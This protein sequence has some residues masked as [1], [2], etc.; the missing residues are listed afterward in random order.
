MITQAYFTDIQQ[1]ILEKIDAAQH[2]IFV[3]VAWL[4]D[5]VIFEKLCEKAKAEVTTELMLALDKI[6][7]EQTSFDHNELKKC[8]G[9]VY[10][11]PADGNGSIMHHKF[12][13]IDASTVITGSYNWS[14]KAKLN[15]EN[16]IVTEEAPELAEQFILEF[17]SIK[18]RIANGDDDT[19]SYDY[20]QIIK[21]LE[22]I[23]IFAA[24]AEDGSI[25]EQAIILN[26]LQLPY[27]IFEIVEQLEKKQYS[28]AIKNIETFIRLKNQLVVF[29]DGEVFGLQLEIKSLEVQLNALDNELVES[30]QLMNEF[31]VRH[32]KE[33]G[34]L[35]LELLELKKINSK[36][37]AERQEADEDEKSYREGYEA[38]KDIEIPQIS[39]E[40][41]KNLSKLFREASFLCHP[42]K[43]V[44]E[45]P[46][47]Q[48]Q[49]EE[50]FKALVNV[51]NNNDV[52]RVEEILNNLKSGI[53]NVSSKSAAQK[54]DFLKVHLNE[55]K[56]KINTTM[57]RLKELKASEVYLTATE[58]PDWDLYF[59]QARTN[60]MNQIQSLKK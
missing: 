60:L 29:E 2:S 56:Y 37:E 19:N 38:K 14:K 55:L 6:N 34:L 13:I 50:L 23:K 52:Q 31:M 57:A 44:H 1:V 49:A 36:T 5:P 35:L 58:N 59:E 21:R 41:K 3:A 9:R 39:P 25:N 20:A 46:E 11:I 40:E 27:E 12:C 10:F 7:S 47:K 28:E 26:A 51:Y 45:T 15:D 22:L 43:F 42:D 17:Q 32:T 54:K 33:L 53:L 30:E 24:L 4:T 16:V 48:K 8:G 18:K